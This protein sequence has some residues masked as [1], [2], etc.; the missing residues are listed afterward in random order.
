MHLN[1]SSLAS[2]IVVKGLYRFCKRNGETLQNENPVLHCLNPVS[3]AITQTLSL[4]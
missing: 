4:Q 1:V 3:L 2:Q